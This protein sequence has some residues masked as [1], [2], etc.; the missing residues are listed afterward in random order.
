MFSGGGFQYL[1]YTAAYEGDPTKVE[2]GTMVAD[3]GVLHVYTNN[4]GVN[5]ERVG[6]RSDIHVVAATRG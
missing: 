5:Q 1:Y 3:A 2:G 6:D 4:N